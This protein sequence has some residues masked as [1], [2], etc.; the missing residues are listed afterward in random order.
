[1]SS[2]IGPAQ[3][4]LR[5]ALSTASI[6][7]QPWAG[8]TSGRYVAV[9]VRLEVKRG[10]NEEEEKGD[11]AEDDDRDVGYNAGSGKLMYMPCV[12]IVQ[13]R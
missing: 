8:I 11:E 5:I 6:L 12:P 9:K 2:E 7:S 4:A 13:S 3:P 1:M 10:R